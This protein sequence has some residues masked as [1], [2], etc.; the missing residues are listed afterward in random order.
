[1]VVTEC[2]TLSGSLI[3]E[4]N[5]SEAVVTGMTKTQEILKFDPTCSSGNFTS[6]KAIVAGCANYTVDSSV[7]YRSGSVLFTYDFKESD[8]NSAVSPSTQLEIDSNWR[9]ITGSVVGAVLGLAVIVTVVILAVPALRF[10][11]FPFMKIRETS[12]R[13]A[14][15]DD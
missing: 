9:F 12:V 3:V 1:V 10:K 4:F 5:A 11:V 15:L 2:A 6:V 8:C 7:S 13:Q 14:N